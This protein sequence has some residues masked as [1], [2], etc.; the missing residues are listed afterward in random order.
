MKTRIISALCMVPFAIFFIIGGL[1][2]YLFN[3]VLTIM[4][5]HE[6]Y[7]GFEN[8]NIHPNKYLGYYSSALL[9]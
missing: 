4:A 3:F 7:N 5:L 2:L 9:F 6:F 1:P 8:I